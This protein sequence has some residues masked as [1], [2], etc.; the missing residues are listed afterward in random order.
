M[1]LS[2]IHGQKAAAQ[3]QASAMHHEFQLDPIFSE[4]LPKLIMPD[5]LEVEAADPSPLDM[6]AFKFRYLVFILNPDFLRLLS[7]EAQMQL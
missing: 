4:D 1:N 5:L 3:Q 7:F 6:P 2:E